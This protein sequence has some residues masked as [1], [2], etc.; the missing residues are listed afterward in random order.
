[1]GGIKKSVEKVTSTACVIHTKSDRIVHVRSLTS[2]R[3][4]FSLPPVR[5]PRFVFPSQL[6]LKF[7]CPFYFCCINY[8]MR[9]SQGLLALFPVAF[10]QVQL[11]R[12]T[13]F[14]HDG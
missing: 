7:R 8:W 12:K 6:H 4:V 3:G 13:V 10:H 9:R 14:V 11:L 5:V 2:R 1:M